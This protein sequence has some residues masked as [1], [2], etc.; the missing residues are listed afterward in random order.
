MLIYETHEERVALVSSIVWCFTF[1]VNQLA[2]YDFIYYVNTIIRL[3]ILQG[4]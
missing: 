1:C 4:K 2:R 3:M